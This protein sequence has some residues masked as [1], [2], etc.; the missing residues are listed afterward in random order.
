[1]LLQGRTRVLVGGAVLTTALVLA[2][3]RATT[4]SQ[5]LGVRLAMPL[6]LNDFKAAIYCPVTVFVNGGNPYDRN[7]LIRSCPRAVY[8]REA[9]LQEAKSSAE[10]FVAVQPCTPSDVFPPYLPATLILHAPFVLLSIETAALAHFF[11]NVALSLAVVVFALRRTAGRVASGDVLLGAGLL[12]LSR[13]GQWNLLLGQSAL[14]L[15]LATFI[16]LYRSR[17]AP[18]LSG[19][20]LAVAAYKPTF[21]IP[22]AL[23]MVARGDTPAVAWGLAFTACLNLPPALL[24]VGRAGGLEPFVADLVQSQAVYQSV[25]D[26]A[27]QVF[28]IDFPGLL[29]RW[30]GG[31]MSSVPYA[32]VG[33]VM[34]VVTGA[35][36]RRVGRSGQEA[37]LSATLICLG[38]L[39]SV[40]HNAYDLVLLVAPVVFVA[41]SS[42]PPIFQQR[43]VRHSLLALFGVLG[44]NYVTTFSVLH[45]LEHRRAAWLVLASL[46]GVLLLTLFLIYVACVLG[47]ARRLQSESPTQAGMETSVRGARSP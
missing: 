8:C 33:I 3:L 18:Y 40:H 36:V 34:L 9:G 6:P 35:V 17:S 29:S 16:A 25:N 20:A 46:N 26:P 12:L 21:G 42:L 7:Q 28:G 1:M 5:L 13:P 2:I 41:R 38:I 22:L 24:L 45:R 4:F 23:L 32:L 14:E 43:S 30:M 27:S 39:L 15:T 11:L 19:L 44:C 47:L 10:P 31:W 37:N